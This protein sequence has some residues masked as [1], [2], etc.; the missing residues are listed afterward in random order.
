[1]L[2][3]SQQ[4]SSRIALRGLSTVHLFILCQGSGR[5]TLVASMEAIVVCKPCLPEQSPHLVEHLLFQQLFSWF[6]ESA[7]MWSCWI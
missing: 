7:W 6:V 3:A 4:A 1:M 5:G 2:D